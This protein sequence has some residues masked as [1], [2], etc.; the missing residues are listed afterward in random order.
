MRRSLPVLLSEI[1]DSDVHASEQTFAVK[2]LAQPLLGICC[3][4]VK[5]MRTV[6]AALF[7][8]CGGGTTLQFRCA[9]G[10]DFAAM[11][12]SDCANPP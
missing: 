4:R 10:E 11:F 2:W 6:T 8:R 9:A 5:C 1:G 3:S 7:V 12:L